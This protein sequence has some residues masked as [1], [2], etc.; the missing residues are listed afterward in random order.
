MA[1][2]DVRASLSSEELEDDDND[3]GSLSMEIYDDELP[4]GRVNRFGIF[5]VFLVFCGFAA[6]SIH[7]F[8]D[9]LGYDPFVFQITSSE[10]VSVDTWSLVH[11]FIFAGV[12]FLFPENTLLTVLGCGTTWEFLELL[13]SSTQRGRAL[14]E[15]PRINSL[16]DLFFNLVGYRLGEA[17]LVW[18]IHRQRRRRRQQPS[19]DSAARAKRD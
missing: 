6:V 13:A 4:F 2:K 14:W 3:D 10:L 17:C 15:E 11:V 8:H 1:S 9:A 5:G 7:A 19:T 12:G 18:W 16:W